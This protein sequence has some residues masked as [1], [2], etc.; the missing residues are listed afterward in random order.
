MQ[1]QTPKRKRA[2]WRFDPKFLERLQEFAAKQK[3][4]TT[5]T[6]VIEVA[7]TEYMNRNP[8]TA[9]SARR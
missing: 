5:Q 2:A 4:R 9:R 7:V 6:E 8:E 1:K 3:L